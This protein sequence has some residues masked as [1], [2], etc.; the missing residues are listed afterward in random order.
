LLEINLDSKAEFF[1]K[2]HRLVVLLFPFAW[3]SPVLRASPQRRIDIKE[4]S[5]SLKKM[6]IHLEINLPVGKSSDKIQ[7]LYQI[8]FDN[9]MFYIGSSAH[10]R[11]RARDWGYTLGGRK[12]N[13]H[14]PK[15]NPGC[16]EWSE[17]NGSW[18]CL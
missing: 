12:G 13:W 14:I 4:L 3:P 7:G 16:N 9:G 18:I 10:L 2:G 6:K 5:L 8:T 1:L 11:R 17:K 15:T